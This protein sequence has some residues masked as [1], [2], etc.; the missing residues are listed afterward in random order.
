MN[1]R[2]C[3]QVYK[4]TLIRDLLSFK[5]SCVCGSMYVSYVCVL[6]S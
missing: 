5:E 1:K 3:H 2:S 6:G 4:I